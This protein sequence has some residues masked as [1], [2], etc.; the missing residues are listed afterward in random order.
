MNQ[1]AASWIVEPVAGAGAERGLETRHGRRPGGHEGSVEV[2]RREPG[3]GEHH[4][5]GE[6]QVGELLAP[7]VVGPQ[8]VQRVREQVVVVEDELGSRHRLRARR[9]PPGTQVAVQ[10]HLHEVHP[11]HPVV[12]LPGEGLV[13]AVVTRGGRVVAGEHRVPERDLRGP[14]ELLRAVAGPPVPG[15]CGHR[16][17]HVPLVGALGLEPE[18]V[19]AERVRDHEPRVHDHEPIALLGAPVGED[20]RVGGRHGRHEGSRQL[21][22]RGDLPAHVRADVLRVGVSPRAARW[23]AGRTPAP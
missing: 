15:P 11:L 13:E 12:L 1:Y 7:L 22:L 18:A 4:L 5:L 23:A 9:G 20:V 17:V 10:G 3:R 21:Q 14:R 8:V 19:R 16:E 6:A 2:R